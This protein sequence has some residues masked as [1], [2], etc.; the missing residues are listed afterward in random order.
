M[1]PDI[2]EDHLG[3]IGL[4]LEFS[5]LSE[6]TAA[7][8]VALATNS[9][10]RKHA[11]GYWTCQ[12][13]AF[14]KCEVYL[15]TRY[16]ETARELGGE[17]AEKLL[18]NVVPVELVTEPFSRDRLP[19]FD[20]IVSSLRDAGAVG[21]RDGVF[22][23]FG[24]HLNIE[25][26]EMDGAAVARRVAAYA[27]L[28]PFLRAEDPIDVSRRMLPFVRPYADAF[29]DALANSLPTSFDGLLAAYLAHAPSRDHGLDMLPLLATVD[30]AR[31]TEAAKG[32]G[33]VKARPA[34]HFRLPD[35]R[36]DEADWS[37]DLAWN[38][39]KLVDAVAQDKELLNKLRRERLDFDGD[40]SDRVSEILSA[41]SH[42]G[43][44]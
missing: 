17:T 25:A 40:W 43:A 10:A 8:V 34:Y 21:S 20:I 41:H 6:R 4:E 39:W 2:S 35:C 33:S 12:T 3:R 30:D 7:E 18:R 23:G 16:A 37:I 1:T 5:G 44:S 24:L 28:E 19:D 22:L 29:V 9:Q 38:Q 31:V 42:L 32:L 14:G 27:L 13:E 11:P 36:I 26:A 15:D